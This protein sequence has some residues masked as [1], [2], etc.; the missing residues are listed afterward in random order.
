MIYG[1]SE[2][3]IYICIYDV[4]NVW[5]D[6]NTFE[7]RQLFQ[8]LKHFSMAGFSGGKGKNT[9]LPPP[10]P[11]APYALLQLLKFTIACE[12]DYNFN[13]CFLA[14][15]HFSILLANYTLYLLK[16]LSHVTI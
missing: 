9:G 15:V 12:S 1:W 5:Y 3:H 8:H 7:M 6:I 11:K 16:I 2:I 13:T 4:C 14:T 10:C